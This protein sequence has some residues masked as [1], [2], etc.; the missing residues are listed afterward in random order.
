MSV[1]LALT[2]GRAHD[3]MWGHALGE[4][5]VSASTTNLSEK[6]WLFLLILGY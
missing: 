6:T 2:W 4:L 1:E 3:D 5:P